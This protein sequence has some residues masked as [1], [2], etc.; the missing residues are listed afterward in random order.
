MGKGN[1]VNKL[2]GC[3][4]QATRS[5]IF[6]VLLVSLTKQLALTFYPCLCSKLALYNCIFTNLCVVVMIINENSER[7]VLHL[8]TFV[9]R[10]N[11]MSGLFFLNSL[12]KENDN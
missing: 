1:T 3:N 7:L 9:Q 2:V 6:K 10:F 11:I 12:T 4:D 5:P 8:E